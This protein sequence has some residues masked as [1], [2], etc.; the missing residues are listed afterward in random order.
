MRNE[1]HDEPLSDTELELFFQYLHR[2]AQHDVDLFA[3]MEAGDPQYPCYVSLT[4]DPLPGT[5]ADAYRR[6]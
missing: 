5:D 3:L 1:R 4:R 2:F 6:P